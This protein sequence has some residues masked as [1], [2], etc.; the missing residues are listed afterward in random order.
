VEESEM[1]WLKQRTMFYGFILSAALIF[2]QDALS[3]RNAN[4]DI[5]VRL[6]P[7]TK[8]L[9]ARQTLT[10]TNKSQ[11]ATDYLPM[12][13]YLNAFSSMRSTF[14]LESG[15]QLRGD[16]MSSRKFG[17]IRIDKLIHEGEDRT[18]ELYYDRPDDGN[19]HDSTVIVLPL[20]RDVLP[21]ETVRLEINFRARLPRV[22]ARTGYAEIKER[23]MT[24]FMVGQWFPKIGVLEEDGWNCHQFHGSTEFFSDFGVYNVYIEV[25]QKYVVGAS[26]A[27]LDSSRIDSSYKRYHYRA[28]DVHDFAWTAY[29]GFVELNDTLGTTALRLLYNPGN[30]RKAR[31]QMDAL[32]EGMAIINGRIGRYPYPTLTVV[33]P[34]PGAGGAAGMEYP[35]LI[36]GGSIDNLPPELP[37][38]H[39]TT[40]LHEYGHQ[41]F[42]GIVASNEFE[43]SWMDE[44]FTTFIEDY[45]VDTMYPT[46]LPPFMPVVKSI[47]FK[48]LAYTSQPNSY[49]LLDT[50][51]M[52]RRSNTYGINAYMRPGTLLETF[53]RLLGDDA[54]FMFMQTYFETWKFRHPYPEDVFAIMQSSTAADFSWFIDDYMRH[55]GK[56]DFMVK[57]VISREIEDT[58]EYYPLPFV[59]QLSN[60]QPADTN[61]TYFRNEISI[62][63]D[64][65]G[66]F[67]VEIVITFADSTTYDASAHVDGLSGRRHFD[68]DLLSTSRIERVEIDPRRVMLID[69][70][71]SNN[72]WAREADAP[73]AKYTGYMKFI[74]RSMLQLIMGM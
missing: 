68:F 36:T 56:V 13:L 42:Y 29:P 74:S 17:Y 21:G 49:T 51:Y 19:P 26:G 35:T 30:E 50:M 11:R 67:P 12:H 61:T 18:A 72:N 45:L 9:T 34:P 6:D 7:A 24:F 22:F 57:R 33:N 10:W 37:I 39:A 46:N 23:E 38:S 40:T 5:E 62:Y 16:R 20:K 73:A 15:G 70:N 28:S 71:F 60:Y 65:D 52:Q 48:R 25:P 31:L 59:H 63:N 3:P 32:K 66:R 54:F 53:R 41:Y 44:G 43:H 2:A 8:M 69:L 27:L 47:D 55:E 58:E 1:Q 64:G 14:V 4:Y